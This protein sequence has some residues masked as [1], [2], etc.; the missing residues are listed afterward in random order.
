MPQNVVVGKDARDVAAFV[1]RYAGTRAKS[2]PSPNPNNEVTPPNAG[3]TG[4]SGATGKAG[5]KKKPGG[6]P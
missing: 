2:P 4:Q 5:A 1:A 3:V 6:K